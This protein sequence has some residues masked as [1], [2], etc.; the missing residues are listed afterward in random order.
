MVGSDEL[1]FSSYQTPCHKFLSFAMKSVCFND[2]KMPRGW[3]S[4]GTGEWIFEELSMEA[5][6]ISIYD[7]W[8]RIKKRAEESG[9][10]PPSYNSFL[11]FVYILRSLGLVHTAKTKV[12]KTKGY[13]KVHIIQLTLEGKKHPDFFVNPHRLKYPHLYPEKRGWTKEDFA[14]HAK[15]LKKES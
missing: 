1:V 11:S 10:C 2:T 8:K 9:F 3:G 14:E 5:E 4:P 12:S 7:L 13:L 6:E 15:T